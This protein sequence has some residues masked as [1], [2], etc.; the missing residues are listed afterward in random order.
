MDP[1]VAVGLPVYNGE[2]F[3]AAAIDSVLQ[4]TFADFELII[5]DNASTDCTQRICHEYAAR[6]PRIRYSR[7]P[8][9]RGVIWNHNQVLRLSASP[10]FLWFCHDDVLAPTYIERCLAVLKGDDSIVLSFSRWVDIDESGRPTA[11]KR[12]PV[13]IDS[14]DPVRRF[15]Q[16]I[17]PHH[18]CEAGCGLIRSETLRKMP[19]FGRFADYD[20]VWLAELALHG[21]FLQLPEV[22]FFHREH[23]GRPTNLFRDSFERTFW[24][25]PKTTSKLVFPNFRMLGEYI[26]A[27]SRAPLSWHQR[28]GCRFALLKW[29]KLNRGLLAHDLRVAGRKVLPSFLVR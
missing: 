7:V 12:D 14:R 5:S 27:T 3:L 13:Q 25:D 23:A 20:R 16:A 22:L 28:M 15:S 11:R 6:D 17:P 10:Y 1:L 8:E 4:Q 18:S 29:A 9:N 19:V 24:L 2:K 21:R 26:V